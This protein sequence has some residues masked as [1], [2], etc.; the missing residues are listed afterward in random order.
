MADGT[1]RT[2]NGNVLDNILDANTVADKKW[3]LAARETVKA[4]LEEHLAQLIADGKVVVA[5]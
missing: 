2:T 4:Y 3:K 5:L 1:G